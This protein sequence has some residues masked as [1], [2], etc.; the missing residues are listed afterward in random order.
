MSVLDPLP[1]SL[2]SLKD[3]LSSHFTTNRSEPTPV[4]HGDAAPI[5][6]DGIIPASFLPHEAH[7]PKKKKKWPLPLCLPFSPRRHPQLLLSPLSLAII[8]PSCPDSTAVAALCECSISG[9]RLPRLLSCPLARTFRP[10]LL[11][12][13]DQFPRGAIL[14]YCCALSHGLSGRHCSSR[15]ID[16][17]HAASQ[18]PSPQHGS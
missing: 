5:I 9:R 2:C 10:L 1:C 17:S 4:N 15:L 14:G 8:V 3:I 11:F 16:L 12:A 13:I 6:A 7:L 18:L